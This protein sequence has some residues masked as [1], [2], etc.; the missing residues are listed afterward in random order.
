MCLAGYALVFPFSATLIQ[1]QAPAQSAPYVVRDHYVK[2][3][4]QVKMRDGVT[5]FTTV[6][7]PKDASKT[8]P[9]LITGTCYSVAPYGPDA[10]RPPVG[11]SRSFEESGDIFVYQDVRGR[12]GSEGTRVEMTRT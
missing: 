9:F 2:A 11:P 4:Y 8:Y 6:Y 7:A 1:A 3:E 10:Y 5:L 12:F